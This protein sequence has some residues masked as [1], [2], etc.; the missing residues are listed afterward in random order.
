MK[1]VL[2]IVIVGTLAVFAMGQDT[3]QHHPMDHMATMQHMPF[4]VA[5]EDVPNGARL[6]LTP[7][8]PEQ[9]E[10]FRAMIRKH[11]EH[12][13]EGVCPMMQMMQGAMHGMAP[14]R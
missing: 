4:S 3:A 5:Y 10:E 14:E 9:L 1:E 2:F 8:D 7:K 12:M 6:T 13:K 11:A